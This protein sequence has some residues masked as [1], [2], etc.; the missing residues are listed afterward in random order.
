MPGF[1]GPLYKGMLPDIPSL[2]S[3]PNFPYMVNPTQIVRP[4]QIRNFNE[5]E[6]MSQDGKRKDRIF[7]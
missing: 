1:N 6:K 4:S 2:L 5:R 3:I 7:C